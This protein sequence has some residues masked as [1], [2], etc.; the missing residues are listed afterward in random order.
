MDPRTVGSKMSL[1]G[2]EMSSRVNSSIQA[3]GIRSSSDCRHVVRAS[4]SSKD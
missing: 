3:D 2:C 1:L 4:T